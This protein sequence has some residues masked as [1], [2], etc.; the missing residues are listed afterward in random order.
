MKTFQIK[1]QLQDCKPTISRT[2]LISGTFTFFDLHV[3]IQDLFG[4]SDYHLWNFTYG[5]RP[6]DVEI[7]VPHDEIEPLHSITKDASKT[8]LEDIF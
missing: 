1:I 3:F 6:N 8:T 5:E 7:V 2:I 4:F